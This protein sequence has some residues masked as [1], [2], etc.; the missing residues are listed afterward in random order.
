MWA[1][2]G[3]ALAGT[4][5]IAADKVAAQTGSVGSADLAGLH[6]GAL[7]V[8]GAGAHAAAAL[9]VGG[10]A[11]CVA[12][13]GREQ[14][15]ILQFRAR[16]CRQTV[17]ASTNVANWGRFASYVFVKCTQLLQTQQASLCTS[18]SLFAGATCQSNTGFPCVLKQQWQTLLVPCPHAALTLPAGGDAAILVAAL[19]YSLATVR[20][21][22]YARSLPPVRIAAGKSAVLAA[23]ALATFLVAAAAN[24]QQG[25]PVSEMWEGW[26]NPV[27]WVVLAW[28]AVGP[29]ALAAYLHVKV[30]SG[31]DPLQEPWQHL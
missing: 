14:L 20:I 11:G 18:Y 24:L 2:C 31:L 1:G 28:S 7:A 10:G 13:G 4:V 27:A 29:G 8:K 25:H 6:I 17:V 16:L 23:V 26:A 19:F 22:G 15:G 30:C 12:G 3:L 5:L 9:C 21:T